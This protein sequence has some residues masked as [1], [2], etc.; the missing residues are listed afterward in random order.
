MTVY[1]FNP[2]P[3]ALPAS[4]LQQA[5]EEMFNYLE[6][7]MSVMELSHRSKEYEGIHFETLQLIR[8]L[9]HVPKDFSI[10][11]MQGGASLQFA[12]IPMNFLTEEKKSSY[13]L[14]GSWSEKALSEAKKIGNAHVHSSSEGDEYRSIPE[15]QDVL[16]DHDL[17]YMHV[18]SNNTIYGTQWS[19]LPRFSNV[20]LFVDM[21]SDIFSRTVTWDDV[22]F[23]YA[24]A[25]KNAGPA[26]VTIVI[27]KNELLN[28]TNKHI[29]AILSYETHVKKDGLYHTPPTNSIYMLGLM[30]KWIKKE[31]GVKEMERRAKRKANL[32]YDV[33]DKSEGFY[34]GH[35]R[36][37]SR[38][39]M[40]ITF[41]LAEQS[42]EDLFLEKIRSDGFV[43]LNGHRSVGGVRASL[44][45]GVP[46]T[47][48][49]ALKDWMETFKKEYL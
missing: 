5:Q 41:R 23:V 26:G 48:V 1:N 45:N 4:V 28:H 36:V 24:G 30:L 8:E 35:A 38:S 49:E 3:A 15:Y 12:M 42:L 25:Q 6:S 43:G 39:N 10:L 11:L 2:G 40:N 37:Q 44:Y 32:L 33:L 47:H 27:L 16:A 14:S 17:S 46:M 18:T 19:S 31:G 13:I 21:S 29:P 9:L 22:D 20:P 34:K 7:G